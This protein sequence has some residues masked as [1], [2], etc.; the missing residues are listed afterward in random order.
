MPAK[1]KAVKKVE[2]PKIRIPKGSMGCYG[3][4]VANVV[5]N[6]IYKGFKVEDLN[7]A[8]LGND[9]SFCYYESDTP[10]I[11]VEWEDII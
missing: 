6:L 11:C 8:Y 5:E 2:K 9:Y 1:K 3:D 4:S 10:S 7:K